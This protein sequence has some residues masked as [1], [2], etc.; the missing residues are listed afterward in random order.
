M[1]TVHMETTMHPFELLANHVFGEFL[2]HAAQGPRAAGCRPGAC[3]PGACPRPDAK[4][5]IR[6]DVVETA[7]AYKIHAELPG[8]PKEAI[9]VE[10]EAG[11][12]KLSVAA[13]AAPED[14][15]DAV[16]VDRPEERFLRNER[17]AWRARNVALPE[18]A[19]LSEIE[20][21]FENG[22][23][24][25]AVKKKPAGVPKSVTIM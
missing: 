9:A 11:E 7:A 10:A 14:G 1:P 12:L 25:V 8:V 15:N 17:R 24:S 19:D 5:R 23:L 3:G 21:R 4:A 16:L 20:A 18:D 6:V 22:L 2:D 13:P